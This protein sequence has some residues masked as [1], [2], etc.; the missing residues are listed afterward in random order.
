MQSTHNHLMYSVEYDVKCIY[1]T[2][3]PIMYI[4]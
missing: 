2:L 4:R 1:S 3:I